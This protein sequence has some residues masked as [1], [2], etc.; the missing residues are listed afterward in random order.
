MNKKLT[1]IGK[2]SVGAI[3]VGQFLKNTDWDIDWI[4]DENIPAAS[5]GEASNLALPI[6]LSYSLNFSQSDLLEIGGSIKQGIHK[7]YWGNGSD[8]LHSFPINS[9]G[10]HFSAK[11]LHKSIFEKVKNN[12]RLKIIN[13]HIENPEEIESDFILVCSGTPKNFNDENI[14]IIDSIP[15]NSV[16]VT[17]CYW[18]NLKFSYSLTHAMKHGWVFGIPLKDRISIG[19][20]F[21]DKLNDLYE[22]KE[23]VENIFKEYSLN[24]SKITNH[25]NFQSFFKKNN[26]S[27]KI[28]YSGNASF[29]LEPLEATSIGFSIFVNRLA[30]DLWNNTMSETEAQ[31]LY[32]KEIKDIELMILLHYMSG[33]I[34]EKTDFWKYSKN[35]ASEQIK[36]EFKQKTDWAN[37]VYNAITTDYDKNKIEFGTWGSKN[38]RIN[39]EKLGIK[40]KLIDWYENY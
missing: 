16:F 20:L 21:N 13:K 22:I 19:Y 18:D 2:G 10:I 14:K 28:I 38:Y 37:F 32:E 26:F 17:Q 36:K 40:E 12:S 1:I 7:K 39:I 30:I 34:Y 6:T 23:D 3:A 35:I 15:V 5:V 27:K 4:F 11:D 9:V 24:P 8:F 31:M 25:L 29:F 33:S